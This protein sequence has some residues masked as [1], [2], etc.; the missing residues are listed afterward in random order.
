VA[1]TPNEDSAT[2]RLGSYQTSLSWEH[3]ARDRSSAGVVGSS[4]GNQVFVHP[5][6]AY[7]PGHSLLI[8]GIVSVPVWQEFRDPASQTRSRIGTG[9]TYAW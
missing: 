4:G 1:Y 3:Y 9:V 2:G 8:F 7:S 5:A 6:I